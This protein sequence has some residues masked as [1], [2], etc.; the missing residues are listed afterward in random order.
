MDKVYNNFSFNIN[1]VGGPYNIY[2][3]NAATQKPLKAAL[4]AMVDAAINFGNPSSTHVEGRAAAEILERSRKTI[5][6]V[7]GCSKEEFFFTPGGT[8]S[9]NIAIFGVANRHKRRTKC[10]VSTD[11]EHPSVENTLRRLE[12]DGFEVIRISTKGGVLDY[13]MLERA[14]MHSVSLVTMMYVNNETGAVYDIAK[15]RQIMN[16]TPSG[17]FL[18]CD[19]IQGFTKEE[20][21]I[22]YCDLI[23]ISGHKIGGIKGCG[24]LYIKQSVN[25]LPIIEGGGQESGM[26]SGTECL[27]A[28]AA[29]AAAAQQ[30][31]NDKD[32]HQRMHKLRQ[33]FIN[34][35]N[36]IPGIWIN[37]PKYPSS[38]IISISLPGV[39][40]EVA[41]NYLSSVGIC[42][43]AG[44]ACSA[45]RRENRV[46][47]AFGLCRE[48]A[49]STIRVSICPE[50]ER[51]ELDAL[52]CELALIINKY[53]R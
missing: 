25:I 18:H 4:D 26:S 50:T 23:S 32:A 8:I 38:S 1:K 46:L 49:D 7:L 35:C 5:S 34:S 43:S 28:I 21:P 45:K 20:N 13:N 44:S 22:K 14:L 52:C 10:V 11:S 27:P 19:N 36:R 47:N 29:F 48:R 31:F 42:V 41:A 3:D 51:N 37:E 24:G 30:R 6:D 12:E 40:S 9:N 2:L 39:R 16:S 33:H 17:A 53:K 15:V